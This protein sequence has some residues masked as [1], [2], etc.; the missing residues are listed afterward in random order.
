MNELETRDE[1]Y[2]E[3][4][5]FLKLLN[6]LTDI[7]LPSALGSGYRVPGFEPYLTF[8]RDDVFLKFSSRGYQNSNEKVLVAKRSVCHPVI[9]ATRELKQDPR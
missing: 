4:R 1:T 7:P 5:A 9:I 2:P 6:N 8:L 3:T